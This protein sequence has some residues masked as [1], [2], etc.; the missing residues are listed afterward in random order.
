M[1]WHEQ[2]MYDSMTMPE[3]WSTSL[4]M[5]VP[6]LKVNS[7]GPRVVAPTNLLFELPIAFARSA[8]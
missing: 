8:L 5:F 1:H 7:A 3:I 2:G 6:R 4:H